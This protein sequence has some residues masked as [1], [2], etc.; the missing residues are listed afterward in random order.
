MPRFGDL[1]AAI[2]DAVWTA[3]GPV[4][5]RDILEKLDRDPAPAYTTVQTVMDI[6]FRKGWLT[7][8]KQGRVNFYEAASSSEDYITGLMD[9]AMS[10]AQDRTAVL[11]KFV[12]GMDPAETAAL[13]ELLDAA[14]AREGTR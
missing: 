5:V 7:R 12:E 10:V 2:M 9:E 3:S 4:R 14:K 11:V 13:R 1:E 6:L 8:A